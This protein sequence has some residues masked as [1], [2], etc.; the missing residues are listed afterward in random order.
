MKIKRWLSL[1]LSAVTVVTLAVPERLPAKEANQ[2][3]LAYEVNAKDAVETAD[4]SA[5]L[6]DSDE[7]LEGYV[8]EQ[9]FGNSG[10][11]AYG[12]FADDKLT[13]LDLQA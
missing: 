8:R 5:D 9:F 7:L 12:N 11:S 3:E 13:G 4:I 10:I 6:S 1:V 2:K